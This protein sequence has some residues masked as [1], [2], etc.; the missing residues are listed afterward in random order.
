MKG[1]YINRRKGYRLDGAQHAALV[2]V[3]DRK[4][5]LVPQ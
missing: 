1:C 2:V 4:T 3:G 5:P